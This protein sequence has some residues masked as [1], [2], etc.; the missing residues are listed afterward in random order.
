LATK[1]QWAE[2]FRNY[3]AIARGM[4]ALREMLELPRKDKKDAQAV[5]LHDFACQALGWSR[6]TPDRF[7]AAMNEE[8]DLFAHGENQKC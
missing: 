5:L 7:G 1:Q 3:E 6:S 2:M 4:V 8:K